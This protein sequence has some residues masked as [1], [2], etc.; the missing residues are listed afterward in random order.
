M[1]RKPQIVVFDFG[2]QTAHLIVRRVRELGVS[3]ELVPH[4]LRFA[5][6][7]KNPRLRGIIFSGGPASI[8]QP[9][10]PRV[11][12]SILNGR[13]PILGICYGMQLMSRELGGAV[14]HGN[15]REFGAAYL[16]IKKRGRLL[17]GMP[18]RSRI[19][20]SHSD[21]VVQL[22]S[23]FSAIASTADCRYAVMEDQ[24]GKR[25]GVQFHPEVEHTSQ[26]QLILR[27]FLFTIA[28]AR[29]DL[30]WPSFIEDAVQSVKNRIGRGR[31]LCGLSGGV[32]SATAAALVSRAIGSRL[33]SVFIDTGLL[34]EG[35]VEEVVKS[36]RNCFSHPLLVVK[37]AEEFLA[38]LRGI[39]DPEQ[40]RARVGETFIRIFEREARKLSDAHGPARFLVQGTIFPDVIESAGAKHDTAALIK[41]HHNVGGLP[42]RMGFQLIEPLRGLY[43]DEV[44]QLARALGMPKSIIW[45]EPFPGPGLGIRIRGEVTGE[46]LERLRRAD[47]ILA[48]EIRRNR[49]QRKKTWMTFAI[50]VPL[51]T[52]GVKGDGRTFEDMIAIRSL[53]S[54]D[55]MTAEWTR[56]P[57]ALLARISSRIVNEVPGVTRVVYDITTKPPATMEWE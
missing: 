22:P 16:V 54:R 1:E 56:L 6:L 25:F 32:D 14:K 46:R 28:G 10:A 57:A 35:E 13:Y 7:Q 12:R 29:R 9:G 23:G 45:R 30:D 41:S 38:A 43:K 47:R 48:D 4:D 19:W 15:R 18:R 8:A 24:A 39:S 55:A 5:A 49:L 51:P 40:K 36:F 34:R 17:R 50:Y 21:R 26:G 53:Q 52:T 2:S 27:N 44:R 3:C 31:A 11:K 42:H 37:A 20:M 33:T